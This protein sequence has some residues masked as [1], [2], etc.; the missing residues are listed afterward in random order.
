M[1]SMYNWKDIMPKKLSFLTTVMVMSIWISDL[2]LANTPSSSCFML[3]SLLS[4]QGQ[5]A[6]HML[7][8]NNWI[9]P[10]IVSYLTGNEYG[11]SSN[12]LYKM[13]ESKR[14]ERINA[15]E[16]QRDKSNLPHAETARD[17]R[18]PPLTNTTAG[19]YLQSYGHCNCES[20]IITMGKCILSESLTV[21]CL[22]W[23]YIMSNCLGVVL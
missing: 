3:V 2:E 20:T 11:R 16:R 5:E 22:I 12:K 6:L 14:C 21:H 18:L 10:L 4:L 1:N 23:F 17:E 7:V 15:S 9:Q 8:R 19:M 13:T